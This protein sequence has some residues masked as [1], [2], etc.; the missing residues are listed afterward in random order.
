MAKKDDPIALRDFL[1][2][3]ADHPSRLGNFKLDR[4]TE[5]AK[6]QLSPA[7]RKM[8]LEGD[9]KKVR[10]ILR[11]HFGGEVDCIFLVV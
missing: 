9:W 7:Q 4:R 3:L 10:E 6:S 11:G 5:L 2:D 8:L 1:V